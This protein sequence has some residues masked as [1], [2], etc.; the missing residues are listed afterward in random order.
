MKKGDVTVKITSPFLIFSCVE[1]T[2]LL[3]QE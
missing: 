3:Q 2:L 1:V